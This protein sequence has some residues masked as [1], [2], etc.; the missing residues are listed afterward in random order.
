MVSTMNHVTKMAPGCSTGRLSLC[1]VFVICLVNYLI[2]REVSSLLTYDRQTLLEIGGF[3][4]YPMNDLLMNSPPCFE[5]IPPFLRRSPPFYVARK[6]RHRR[7]GKRGGV[8]VKLK[9][10]LRAVRVSDRGCDLHLLDISPALLSWRTRGRWIRPVFPDV[11]AVS[12]SCSADPDQLLLPPTCWRVPA[13][14]RGVDRRNLRSLKRASVSLDAVTLD[15]A[16]LNVRSVTNKTFLLNDFF[17]SRKLDFMFLTETWLREGELSPFTELLPPGCSFFSSPRTTGKGGGLASIFKSTFHCLQSHADSYSSFELQL[18]E[19]NSP[20]T[21]LC[22][23]IYRPPKFNK[24]F[25]REFADFVSCATLKYDHFLCVGDFNVHLC[26]E[27]RP[28]VRDFLN[29]MDSFNLT[30]SVSVPTHEKGH[31]LD[32]VLSYGLNVQITEVCHIPLSDHFPVLFS[33]SLLAPPAVDSAPVRRLRAFNSSTPLQFSTAFRDSVLYSFNDFGDLSVDLCMSM[34]DTLCTEILDCI[35]P[36]TLKRIKPQT[37]P[38]LN[39]ATHAHRRACRQAERKWKKDKLQI[40]WDILRDSLLTYQ[41]TVK[42]AKTEYLSL[43]VSTNVHKPQVL[44]NVFDSLV[45]PCDIVCVEP[46]PSLCEDFLKY[47]VNKI[48]TLRSALPQPAQDPSAPIASSAVFNQFE[49]VTTSEL[50]RIVKHLRPANCPTDCIPSRLFKEAFSSVESFIVKLVNLCL[51]SGCV[52]SSFKHATVQPLLKK[53]NLDSSVLANFRP[54][55]KLPFISKILEKVVFNQLQE[56]L[57]GANVCE[58]FQS[59]FK[60]LHSTETALLKV[61][62]DL[63][64]NLDSGNCAIL[65]LLDLTAAFDTVDHSILLSRLEHCAG[66]KGTVLSWFKSYLSGRSFSVRMGECSSSVAPLTSGV[67]Q[68]SVLGPLLFSFYMLPLGSIFRKHDIPFHCF[69]DDMQVHLPIKMSSK[70]SLQALLDCMRDIKTWL[71]LNF[72]KLNENKTEVVLFGRPDLVQVLA[73]SLGPLAPFMRSHARNLCVIIDGAFKLDKQVSA[74]VKSSFFQLRLL[75]KV[76]PYVSQKDLE[77]VIHAF[78]TS[79]L[80]YCNSLYV[81]IDEMLQLAC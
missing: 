64:L 41:R 8:Q 28:M 36:L 39:E 19:V 12:V 67:P 46:S 26:C 7:R 78:I 58:P 50:T 11:S 2:C 48:S 13:G 20:V 45:N 15:L 31:T 29:L 61:F 27:T 68:G 42:A 73:S 77:R 57:K 33:F 9:A 38:W 79:R 37:E 70:Y 16:L 40:S 55:S 3:F 62:N 17:T 56:F 24:D 65:I 80:D 34:F 76:K 21:L 47:F 10:H 66:I 69:A 5:E 63:L 1:S 74:V 4:N 32:L 52:P 14:R 75:A 18:I 44:F 54:I 59:G 53:K 25:I 6:K 35:A 30:Q 43:L 81:G 72:L 71:D 22:A 51:S 49:P 23:V 60:P